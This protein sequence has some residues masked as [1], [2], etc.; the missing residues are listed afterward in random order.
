MNHF[1]L[2]PVF[3]HFFPL[4][5]LFYLPSD[6]ASIVIVIAVRIIKT[7]FYLVARVRQLLLHYSGL[8]ATTFR[9]KQVDGHE[10]TNFRIIIAMHRAP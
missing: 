6:F 1:A 3:F 10:L 8:H 2:F 4:M 9:S 5:F 7:E